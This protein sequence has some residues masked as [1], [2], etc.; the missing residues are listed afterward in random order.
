M[1]KSSKELLNGKIYEVRNTV[2]DGIYIGS[3]CQT[4]RKR[5]HEYRT[6]SVS[7]D[8]LLYDKMR[9]LGKEHFYIELVEDYPCEDKYQLTARGQYYIRD[10]GT[11]NNRATRDA[12]SRADVRHS[13][14][15]IK[16]ASV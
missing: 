4:L 1:D 6:C 12:P 13:I 16:S 7:H 14:S 8:G 15:E 5:I 2:N 11:L 9:Q 3:T 10:R